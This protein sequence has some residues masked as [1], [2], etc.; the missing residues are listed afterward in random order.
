M[1]DTA[2]YEFLRPWIAMRCSVTAGFA[3]NAPQ[4]TTTSQVSKQLNDKPKPALKRDR[5]PIRR[6]NQ[7]AACMFLYR[8]K[9]NLF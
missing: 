6:E 9:R 3:L 2:H 5:A 8:S 7:F 4:R 1:F